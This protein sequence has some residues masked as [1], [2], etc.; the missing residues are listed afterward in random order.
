MPEFHGND[1]EMSPSLNPRDPRSLE[2]ILRDIDNT[3]TMMLG[4][5]R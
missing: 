3:I 1:I 2:I 4:P 5:T